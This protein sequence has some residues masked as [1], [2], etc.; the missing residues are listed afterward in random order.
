MGSVKLSGVSGALVP[1]C[2]SLLLSGAFVRSLWLFAEFS[3]ALSGSRRMVAIK[4]LSAMRRVESGSKQSQL[5][6]MLSGV[7]RHGKPGD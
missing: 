1:L 5:V 7:S 4:L 2:D 3:A 6:H